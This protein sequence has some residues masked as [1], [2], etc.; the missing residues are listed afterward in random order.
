[1]YVHPEILDMFITVRFLCTTKRY[2]TV[3]VL[4]PYGTILEIKGKTKCVDKK[5][6]IENKTSSINI[7]IIR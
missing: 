4:V 3:L 1:M 6:Q 5:E 7:I 2:I